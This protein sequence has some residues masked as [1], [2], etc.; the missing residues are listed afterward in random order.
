MTPGHKLAWLTL[1]GL[2]GMAFA[3]AFDHQLAK[4]IAEQLK[5]FP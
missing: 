3:V 4:L 2:L 1:G 5:N